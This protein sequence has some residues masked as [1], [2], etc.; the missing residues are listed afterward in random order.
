[1]ALIMISS[2]WAYLAPIPLWKKALLCL[3]AFPLAIER[4]DPASALAGRGTVIARGGSSAV[5]G[6]RGA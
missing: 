1:M 2:V 3:A 4:R 5:S 6:W